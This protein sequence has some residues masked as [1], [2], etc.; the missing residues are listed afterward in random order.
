MAKMKREEA[1]GWPE[2][3]AYEAGM[4]MKREEACEQTEC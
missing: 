3:K 1:C 4:E 2:H